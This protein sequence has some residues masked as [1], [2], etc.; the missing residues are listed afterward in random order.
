MPHAFTPRRTA[1]RSL[2]VAAA[3]A[4]L[5]TLLA[6]A[7]AAQAAGRIVAE[8]VHGPSLEVS[9]V[10]VAPDRPVQVYLP[11]GYDEEPGRRYPVVYL[12]HGFGGS[13]DQWTKGWPGWSIADALDGLIGSGAVRPMILVMPDAQTPLVNPAYVNSPVQGGWE[14]FIARDLVRHVDA[15]YRTDARPEARG[16]AGHSMGGYGALRIAM[17]HP[18]VFSLV[19]GISPCCVDWGADLSPDSARA[20][21]PDG[22]DSLEEYRTRPLSLA[23]LAFTLGAAWSPA[24][25]PSTFAPDLP[26]AVAA[27][28]TRKPDPAVIRLWEAQ[29]PVHA[30][31]RETANLKRLRGIGFEAGTRDEYAHILSGNRALSRELTRLGVEHRFVEHDANHSGQLPAR[32]AGWVLPFFSERFGA[33]TH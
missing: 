1:A 23:H 14:D 6:V 25:D 8:T 20:F 29:M 7:G 27:D 18:D 17:R 28:G 33:A 21:G 10:G 19:Y 22:F 31:A 12:L 26:V 15:A 32:V 13:A 3:G 2:A 30:A 16:I 11:P 24:R 9:R 4:F 5:A